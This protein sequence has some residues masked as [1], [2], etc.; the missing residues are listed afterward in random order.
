MPVKII[1]RFLRCNNSDVC[2]IDCPNCLWNFTFILKQCYCPGSFKTILRKFDIIHCRPIQCLAKF[3]RYCNARWLSDIEVGSDFPKTSTCCQTPQ[4]NCHS[5]RGGDGISN[6]VSLWISLGLRDS[7][8]A[9]RY[10]CVYGNALSNNRTDDR[11]EGWAPTT[12][13][14]VWEVPNTPDLVLGELPWQP[15][16]EVFMLPFEFFVKIASFLWSGVG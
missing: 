2:G 6:G 15:Q 5:L 13:S 7:L 10:P 9:R 3:F 8:V 16:Q 4:S 12:Q 14:L 1:E 11:L